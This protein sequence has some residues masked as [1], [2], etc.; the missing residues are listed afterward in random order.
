MHCICY[1]FEISQEK[2]FTVVPMKS[3]KLFNLEILGYMVVIAYL[4]CQLL[5][6]Q[7]MAAHSFVALQDRPYY[8]KS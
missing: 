5:L 6:S 8:V 2:I 4:L 3:V 7:L 1:E